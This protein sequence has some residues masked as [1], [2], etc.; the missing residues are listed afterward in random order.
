VHRALNRFRHDLELV[1]VTIEPLG[2]NLLPEVMNSAPE[3]DGVTLG[4]DEYIDITGSV[5]LPAGN[6]AEQDHT[7]ELVDLGLEFRQEGFDRITERVLRNLQQRVLDALQPLPVHLDQLPPPVSPGVNEIKRIE[8]PN[9]VIYRF[10]TV[11]GDLPEL[12]DREPLVRIPY[13]QRQDVVHRSV[14]ED[15]L[16]RER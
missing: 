14:P 9:G 5:R 3:W 15:L 12:T 8:Q 16:V 6:T 10:A 1:P 11:P 2:L 13:D 4:D 7:N